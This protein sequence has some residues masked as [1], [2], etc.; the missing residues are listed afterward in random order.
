MQ[1][2]SNLFWRIYCTCTFCA[3]ITL[4]FTY[5]FDL[6]ANK[7]TA[8]EKTGNHT[9]M[10]LKPGINDSL[11]LLPI[12]KKLTEL[13]KAVAVAKTKGINTRSEEITI[14]IAGLFLNSYIPWDMANIEVLEKA[15]TQSIGG[16]QFLKDSPKHE[17]ARTPVWEL[18]QTAQILDGALK[19]ISEI[20]QRPD[21]RRPLPEHN[22]DN[23][24]IVNGFLSA[25]GNAAFSGGFIWAPI[26]MNRNFF[27]FMGEGVSVPLSALQSNGTISDERINNLIKSMDAVQATGQKGNIS[28]G[29]NIP[30]WAVS[31]W[32]DINKYT[33]H[34]CNYDIDHP[35]VKELWA[36]LIAS[37]VPKIRN[38][39]SKFAYLLAIE[40]QWPSIGD[41]QVNNASPYTF[42]KY[43]IWLEELYGTINGLNKSW[44]TNYTLFG[45]IMTRP[46][47]NSNPAI[48]YDWCRFNQWRVT[49]LFE[50][51]RKE[52]LKYD[53]SALCH[54]RVS[55]GGIHARSNI[56]TLTGQHSGID[57]EAL[58]NMMEIN[59]LDNFM[60]AT[61]NRRTHN[62]YDETAYSINW[63]GHTMLLDFIRSLDPDKLIYD[64]EWHTVSSVYYLN[65]EP[66]AGYMTT[67]LWSGS[68]H[69]M[70]A[71]T[72][73]FWNRNSNGSIIN[74]FQNEAY[75]SPLVQPRLLNEYGVGLAE[76][77]TFAK[78]VVALEREQKQIYLLYSESSAIQSV[79]YL[80]NQM[81]TYEALQFTG[82][83]TGFVTENK[84]KSKGL[85]ESCKWLIIADAS[86]V[87]DVTI[88]WLSAY[89]KKGGKLLIIGNNALKYNEYGKL[90][91]PSKIQFLNRADKLEVA[92]T[93][94]LLH[95]IESLMKKTKVKRSIRCFDKD[96]RK[97]TA[98]GILCRSTEFE[99]G[100]LVCLINV[101]ANP[102]EV[103]L[104][105][106]GKIIE[107]ALDLFENKSESV[108]SI[109][110]KPLE[111]R[112][113]KI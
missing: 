9:Q 77:N 27:G 64:S 11:N 35:Q 34:H 65:P 108:R 99:G 1:K 43:G 102:K 80:N 46:Q 37:L 109:K 30:S 91:Y 45:E 101:G 33:T 75:G 15:Y 26:S 76:L 112:L 40:P 16:S 48:W 38:H 51:M 17:A 72:T 28:F 69:G 81:V 67:A 29:H 55:V 103:F 24:T 20:L 5:P 70:G 18:Q 36:K 42:K 57:R 53:S 113:I 74:R 89:V 85:P 90:T 61:G 49:D 68:I 111:I 98:L 93:R 19:R 2:K 87:N 94:V 50:F 82:L 8:L 32:P 59:G 63:L 39:P 14:I 41:W 52:I 104:E 92:S 7:T 12:Q 83:P 23:M 88:D 54:I 22:I 56:N 62:L 97:Q 95:Q 47:D 79:E 71:T 86:H 96:L 78:E 4:N 105:H 106:D 58:V 31:Q 110:I 60:E 10:V 3:I 66:P 21:I 25:D 84:L 13:E 44:G 6:A 100:H 73:W 107:K